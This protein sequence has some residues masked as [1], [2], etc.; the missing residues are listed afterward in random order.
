[1]KSMLLF[2]LL[3]LSGC[4]QIKVTNNN[5]TDATHPHF[6]SKIDKSIL[7]SNYEIKGFAECPMD[8]EGLQT[9]IDVKNG[10]LIPNSVA[11]KKVNNI[12]LSISEM[13]EWSEV[14][15]QIEGSF[16]P[17]VFNIDDDREVYFF[18]FDGT[19]N[20]KDSKKPR[21]IPAKLFEQLIQLESKDA[22]INVKYYPGVG[23]RTSIAGELW[24]GFTGSGAKERADKALHELEMQIENMKKKPH[25]YTIGFSRGAA[26]A[27]H[28][29]NLV[30]DL[31]SKEQLFNQT[32][33]SLYSKPRLYSMLFDTV[34][35]GQSTELTLNIPASVTSVIHFVAASEERVFFPV[36]RINAPT[37]NVIVDDRIVEVNLPGVHSDIGGGYGDTLEQLSH[38]LANLWL[39]RQGIYLKK[40][41]YDIQAYLNNGK[42]DSRWLR[43]GSPKNNIKRKESVKVSKEQTITNELDTKFDVMEMLERAAL[44]A[45]SANQALLKLKQDI[46][47]GKKKTFQGLVIN[48][49]AIDNS[50]RIETNCPENV[51][52]NKD[53]GLIEVL[54]QPF[55]QLTPMYLEQLRST[56]GLINT[57]P[58]LKKENYV[59]NT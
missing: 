44:S 39:E 20:D 31:Y 35:T 42:N 1:M 43:L 46:K 51:S 48:L 11:G 5:K 21:T 28:F 55:I 4:Q 9:L 40:T 27:R 24:E 10:T 52:I 59:P 22:R 57:Y 50:L 36:T 49:T 16:P 3:L 13:N 29:L 19:W 32:E 8:L 15:N 33:N 38:L 2:F 56:Y 30:N 18:I 17:A 6:K 26:S 45:N 54:G 53:K 12:P 14:F 37:D 23:T 7:P 25:V 34:A 47:S 58:P 41:N